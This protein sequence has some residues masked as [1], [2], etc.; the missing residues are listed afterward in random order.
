M[1]LENIMLNLKSQLTKTT[2]C[3]IQL[4]QKVQTRQSDRTTGGSLRMKVRQVLGEM[5]DNGFTG[6]W[7]CSQMFSGYG[8]TAL[9]IYKNHWIIYVQWVNH[10]VCELYLKKAITKK[11]KK[12]LL[13]HNTFLETPI[14]QTILTCVSSFPCKDLSTPNW[15]FFALVQCFSSYTKLWVPQ[16]R[17]LALFF[18]F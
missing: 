5:G 1:N 2:Y 8:C 13:F 16:G 10:L 14:K 7:K 6:W 3:M 4:I 17:D 12:V 9:W 18:F 11:K 15:Y